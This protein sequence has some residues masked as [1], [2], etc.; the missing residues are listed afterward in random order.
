MIR[1]AG[2]ATFL[3]A[4]AGIAPSTGT[5]RATEA[6]VEVM[7]VGVV[8]MANTRTSVFNLEVPDVLLPPQQ[9]EI[10]RMTE[11]LARFK[12]TQ[13]HVE[14]EEDVAEDYARYLAGG[15]QS[16]RNEIVQV[17]FRLAKHVGLAKVHASD[18]T[19]WLDYGPVQA[20]VAGHAPSQAVW[21]EM[22]QKAKES[23]D[24]DQEFLDK[25]GLLALLRHYNEPERMARDHLF[26]RFLLPIGEGK[27]QPGPDVVATWYRRNLIICAKIIQAA[28]PG[29]RLAVFF[30]AMH[31]YV[32][33]QC[34]GETPGFKVIDANDY[35][36]E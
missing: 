35:L 29:D 16:D 19:M 33:R 32:L 36:P 22:I 31:S 4:V 10:I 20:F 25:R 11:G 23:N 21:V 34:I 3:A 17:A 15:L 2:L 28:K 7:V 18:V 5:A 8:H 14:R 9:A 1:I 6:P 26:Q 30:G 27:E 13:V 24:A 12:P